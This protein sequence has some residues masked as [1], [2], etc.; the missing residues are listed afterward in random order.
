MGLASGAAW[1]MFLTSRAEAVPDLD[2][3]P[4]PALEI[5]S[6]TAHAAHAAHL[7]AP[8]PAPGSRAR[9]SACPSGGAMAAVAARGA[10]AF[11]PGGPSEGSP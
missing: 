6:V 10:D 3:F 9:A 5:E 1:I 8:A 4:A 2:P 7:A 11:G